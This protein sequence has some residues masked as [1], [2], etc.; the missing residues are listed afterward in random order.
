MMGSLGGSRVQKKPDEV[1]R[2]KINSRTRK[3][4]INAGK[5]IGKLNENEKKTPS[6]KRS[7]N[8]RKRFA[9]RD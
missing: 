6:Q 7:E 9:R 4:L 2:E 3:T 5:K 8:M 1:L